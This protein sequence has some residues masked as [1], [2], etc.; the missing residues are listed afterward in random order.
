MQ[1]ETVLD[2]EEERL[3][4]QKFQEEAR[5]RDKERKAKEAEKQKDEERKTVIALHEEMA[6]KAHTFDTDG[7]IIWVEEIKVDKLPKVT[8]TFPYNIKKDVRQL[9][10]ESG[11]T[12]RNA[13]NPQEGAASAAAAAGKK[14]RRTH[15]P[16]RNNRKSKVDEGEVEFTDGFSKLQHGQPPILDTM[17]VQSGVVLESMGKKK[18]GADI[19]GRNPNQMSRK[20][21][22][23]LAQQEVTDMQFH[24]DG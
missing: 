9:R 13:A 11:S 5:K 8:E 15:R 10:T 19:S 2:E 18:A 14:D 21:Y 23:V 7:K 12:T 4:D 20:E 22:V 1:E 24:S 16:A 3:R 6:R 17:S